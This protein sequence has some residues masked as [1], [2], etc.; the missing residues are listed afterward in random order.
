[1]SYNIPNNIITL[2]SLADDL[3]T[4]SPFQDWEFNIVQSYQGGTAT[5]DEKIKAVRS[6]QLHIVM[7]MELNM[8]GV[9]LLMLLGIV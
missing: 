6:T 3:N 1:M 2:S 4:N 8:L 7:Y 5:Q 9:L